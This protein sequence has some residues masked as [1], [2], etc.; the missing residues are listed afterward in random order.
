VPSFEQINHSRLST[1][2]G[3]SPAY[4]SGVFKVSQAL[5]HLP[6]YLKPLPAHLGLDENTYLVAKGAYTLPEQSIVEQILQS[7]AKWHHPLMPILDIDSFLRHIAADNIDQGKIGI[8]LLQAMLY[9]GAAHVD[10]ACLR[11][12]GYNDRHAARTAFYRK[13]RVSQEI[14]TSIHMLIPPVT[15]RLRLRT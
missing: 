12:A 5:S 4:S 2:P 8:L 14:V 11:K 9:T 15:L 13:A 6:K 3:A 10:L 7:Y 1:L